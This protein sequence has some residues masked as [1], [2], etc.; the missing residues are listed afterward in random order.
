MK[1]KRA[2]K[3]ENWGDDGYMLA[4]RG[5]HDIEIFKTECK[6]EYESIAE[7]LERCNCPCEQFWL[8]RIPHKDYLGGYNIPVPEGTR[9][10]FPV[11][12][13]WE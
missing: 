13:W 5:H 4:S 6:K 1:T 9:G 10:A 2:L 8:K 11:T 7:Y 3:I 12:M